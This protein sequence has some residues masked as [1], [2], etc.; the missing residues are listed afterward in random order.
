MLKKAFY[1]SIVLIILLSVYYLT[2]K[3]STDNLSQEKVLETVSQIKERQELELA[4]KKIYKEAGEELSHRVQK[5][6]SDAK[7]DMDF[8]IAL[9]PSQVIAINKQVSKSKKN[10]LKKSTTLKYMPLPNFRKYPEGK[11]RKEI[12][13]KYF[14]YLVESRNQQIL[15]M[16]KKII[17][18]KRDI[19]NVTFRQ[20]KTLEQL[21]KKYK[22][23]DFDVTKYK[24]WNRLLAR[25][26]IVPASLALAQAAKESLWGTSRFARY[27]YNYYGQ[28]CFS[29]G[30]G[31]VPKKR[32]NRKFEV[33]TFKSPR[34]SV[35]SYIH[36]LNTHFHYE[37]LRK[38]RS[39]ERARGKKIKGLVLVNALSKYSER[40]S[41]YI[42]DLKSLIRYN[43][44]AKYDVY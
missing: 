5:I 11:E 25:L 34:Q 29:R 44:L 21:A 38:I 24:S 35:K 2:E 6:I 22:V 13:F 14:L 41:A 15:K 17:L 3:E 28:H 31:I 36:N 10:I 8:I 30:C 7:E 26:D 42:K 18:W 33:S 39:K 23:E 20:K 40:G 37:S 12:F 16:R 19:N 27:G 32:G 1:T 9:K 43:K 4:I